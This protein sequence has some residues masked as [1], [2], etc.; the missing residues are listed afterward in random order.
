MAELTTTL[1]AIRESDHRKQKFLAAIQGID[2]DSN[3]SGGQKQWE[4]LKSRVFSGG[5]ATDSNDIV[6][7]QGI[8]ASQAGFG[9][10]MGLEYTDAK[11]LTQIPSW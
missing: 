4:D 5:A 1:S 6:S 7:L 11:D 3:S 9:I 8:N 10:G 2:L